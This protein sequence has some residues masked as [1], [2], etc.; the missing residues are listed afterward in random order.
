MV[1]SVRG[2]AVPGRVGEPVGAG[3]L[4]PAT[5]ELSLAAAQHLE[6]ERADL[7]QLWHQRRER[8]AYEVERA[9]RQYH[10]C[11]PEHPLVARPLETEW[12]ANLPAP[13]QLVEDYQRCLRQ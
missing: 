5:L 7:E 8:A 13:Q 6:R 9:A 12:E 11:E 10:P 3:G 4:E 1:L 2:R